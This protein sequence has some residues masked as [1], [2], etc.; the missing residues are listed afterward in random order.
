MLIYKSHGKDCQQLRA[1]I[2][3]VLTKWTASCSWGVTDLSN[4]ARKADGAACGT[5]CHR[6]STAAWRLLISAA[7]EGLV[8]RRR[9]QRRW[10]RCRQCCGYFVGPAAAGRAE[11]RW[12]HRP[13]ESSSARSSLFKTKRNGE[14]ETFVQL[15]LVRRSPAYEYRHRSRMQHG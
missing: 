6:V 1:A 2:C 12:R 3:K 5:W 10:L 11:A 14:G 15:Q 9:W 4:F 8:M 13:A 7:V